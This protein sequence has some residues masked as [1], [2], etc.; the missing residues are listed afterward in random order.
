MTIRL[1]KLVWAGVALLVILGLVRGCGGEERKV[2]RA[3]EDLGALIERKEGESQLA[4]AD[5]ARRLGQQFTQDFQV[6]LD[7]FGV[8]LGDAQAL[9]RSFFSYRAGYQ[10]IDVAWKDVEIEVAPEGRRSQVATIAVLTGRSQ[11][12]PARESYRLRFTLRKE[13]GLWKIHEAVL[14]EVIEGLEG[15]L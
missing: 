13:E 15:L 9:G 7:P 2:R 6:R 12:G 8:T 14:V 5:K 3:L 11:A 1:P 4:A 10:T